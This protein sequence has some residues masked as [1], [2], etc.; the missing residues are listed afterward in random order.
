MKQITSTVG[1]QDQGG[2]LL[3]NGSIILTLPSGVYLIVA[4]GGQVYGDSII[5]NLNN[6]GKIS[7][8]VNIWASD[9]IS[10]QTPYSVTLCAQANGVQPVSTAS[11]FIGGTSPI[12]LSQMISSA[13]GPSYS[14]AVVLSP[15][16]QQTING[17][18]L[19]LE[20]A[21]LGFSAAGS[22]VA[23]TFFS[24]LSAGVVAVGTAIGNALGT[25]I[26][27]SIKQPSGS[28]FS[29]FD[30]LGVS[31]LF[32][33]SSSPYTN[34]FVNGNGAGA[35]FI[36]SASKTSIADTTGNIVTAG[37]ITLQTTSQ[38]L[39]ATVVNDAAG[40]VTATSNGGKSLQWTNAGI[41]V[42][43]PSAL[44]RAAALTVG[45]TSSTTGG[46][47]VFIGAS[48]SQNEVL[49]V[50]PTDAAPAPTRIAALSVR[51]LSGGMLNG[52]Q[53]F[54]VTN[55]GVVTGA[56]FGTGIGN[57]G[58]GFKH[59]RFGATCTTAAGAGATCTSAY[60]WTTA[61]ADANYTVVCQGI[62]QTNIPILSIEGITASGFTARVST[63]IAS[64]ASYGA[65]DCIA[66]HD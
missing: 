56:S 49:A 18:T 51:S 50:D 62:T 21:S 66:V 1:F 29:I 25:L 13:A 61:F 30:A 20:G 10:P 44:I 33:S 40:G 14:G 34:T 12:D 5:V 55:A 43:N 22:T 46:I 11:W 37:S 4:G 16:G 39:P 27:G 64:A 9:E 17:Q 36:G 24:R 28:Q 15:T 63:P 3:V 35:V 45:G 58:S 31:H 57:N 65:V 6:L 2:N 23:D 41:L 53:N 47:S 52:T 26:T 59:A 42:V 60:T 54:G 8:T 19:D 32:I 38:T 7:G 48:G